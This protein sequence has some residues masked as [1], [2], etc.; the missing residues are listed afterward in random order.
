MINQYVGLLNYTGTPSV[1]SIFSKTLKIPFIYILIESTVL[2]ETRILSSVPYKVGPRI[3]LYVG[4]HNST[5]RGLQWTSATPAHCFL[6][7]L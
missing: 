5:Y 6:G 2:N 4:S 3:Q 7:H 1:F